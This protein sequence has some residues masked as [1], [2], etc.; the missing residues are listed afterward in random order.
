MWVLRRIVN[1]QYHYYGRYNTV[2]YRS[3]RARY[4]ETFLQYAHVFDT[5]TEAWKVALDS[6]LVLEIVDH[7]KAEEEHRKASDHVLKLIWTGNML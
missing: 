6:T 4:D 3:I 7:K 1:G 5:K 2:R